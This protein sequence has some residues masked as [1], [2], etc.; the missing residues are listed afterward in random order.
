[1]RE[2]LQKLNVKETF[3]MS[4]VVN[5]DHNILLNFLNI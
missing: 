1:M 4:L 3:L 5:S 2:T